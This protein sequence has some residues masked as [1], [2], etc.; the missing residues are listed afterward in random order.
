MSSE[1]GNLAISLRMQ[2]DS[3]TLHDGRQWARDIVDK[4]AR[5]E[6]RGGVY[7]LKAAREVVAAMGE[8][9]S[10]QVGFI[11]VSEAE[12]LLRQERAAHAKREAGEAT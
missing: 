6:F 5:G 4:H 7:A 11:S 8:K 1:I 2:T 12:E 3:K 10:I 9:S